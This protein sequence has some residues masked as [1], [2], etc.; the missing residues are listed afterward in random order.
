MGICADYVG[1]VV[2]AKKKFV[3]WHHGEFN[4]DSRIIKNW[5]NTLKK[6]DK[7]ICVS[8]SSKQ[9][10][11][12]YFRDVVNE[13]LVIP[14]MINP[15][16]IKKKATA[17]HPYEKKHNK[18]L[19][20]VGRLSPEKKMINAVYAMKELQRK[21]ITDVIWYLVGD[22][23]ERE[24]IEQEI[25]NNDLQ[26]KVICVGNKSNPYPYIA[27]ADIFVHPSY[28]E[29]QGITVLEA[30][31]L[32]KR[33]LITDSAGTR[34]FVVDGENASVAEQSVESLAEHLMKMLAEDSNKYNVDFQIQTVNR[35]SPQLISKKVMNLIEG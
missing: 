13:I 6:F 5:R 30:F 32:K 18:I 7:M 16:E 26:D 9:L 27:D 17:F 35:F 1:Y 11:S 2:S 24:K 20:S 22:G 21:G 29:S 3:W 31:A 4:Y 15:A 19:V 34:E 28:V 33:C 14:N 10:I 23:S 8:E 12:P 25:I